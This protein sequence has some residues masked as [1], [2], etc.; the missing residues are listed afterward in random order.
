[1]LDFYLLKVS[2]QT[3]ALMRVDNGYYRYNKV[4]A[5]LLRM[6]NWYRPFL[7]E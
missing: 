6:N 5:D 1:M 7:N 2:K 4:G 3:S